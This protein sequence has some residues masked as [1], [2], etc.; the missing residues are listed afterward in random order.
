MI[1]KVNN[2][3]VTARP[4]RGANASSQRRR[5]RSLIERQCI[6]KNVAIIDK[7]NKEIKAALAD[8]KFKARLAD[9]SGTVIPGLP[10]D[11]AKL[12]DE[13]ERWAKV[14]RPISRRNRRSTRAPDI[15][16]SPFRE[17]RH[18]AAKRIDPNAGN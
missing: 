12:I 17:S 14:R 6:P 15:P 8:P 3:R 9:L 13:S 16:C 7:L 18:V 10:A 5:W 1:T 4:D 11:F 2:I